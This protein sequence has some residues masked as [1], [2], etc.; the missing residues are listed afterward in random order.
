MFLH[1][2][3]LLRAQLCAGRSR[4]RLY[5]SVTSFAAARPCAEAGSVRVCVCSRSRTKLRGGHRRADLCHK[6]PCMELHRGGACAALC[7]HAQVCGAVLAR[8]GVQ[9]CGSTRTAQR[10]AAI[11]CIACWCQRAV[12]CFPLHWCGFTYQT[13]PTMVPQPGQQLMQPFTS[14]ALMRRHAR[15][16]THTHCSCS[17][18]MQLT[19]QLRWCC[20]P[21]NDVQRGCLEAYLHHALIQPA[22]ANVLNTP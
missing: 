19:S 1:D 5:G 22:I 21:H 7:L 6:R 20:C 4:A 13:S 8:P 3:F 16:H 2:V 10:G 17:D 14:R 9:S 18:S 11:C 15:A 12:H